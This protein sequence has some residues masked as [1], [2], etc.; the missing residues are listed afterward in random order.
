MSNFSS[1]I[2]ATESA[3][4]SLGSAEEENAKRMDSAQGK[5]TQLQSAWEELA[6]KTLSSDTVK[7]FLS[8]ATSLVKIADA[9]GGL[10]PILT[11]LMGVF[12]MMNATKIASFIPTMI[13]GFQ[14]MMTGVKAFNIAL[15]QGRLGLATYASTM[16]ATGQATSTTAALTAA[17]V[18][19]IGAITIAVS[20]L[21]MAYNSYQASV[22]AGIDL[23]KE[24]TKTHDENITAL[25]EAK[26]KYDEIA[27]STKSDADKKK[28]LIT[29]QK[30]L[31]SALKG[32]QVELSNE[33]GEINKNIEAIKKKIKEEANAKA[34]AALS[35]IDTSKTEKKKGRVVGYVEETNE[36]TGKK[37]E[38]SVSDAERINLWK[39]EVELIGA[40][41]NATKED[42]ATANKF[43][44]AVAANIGWYNEQK[45]AW[46]SYVDARRE[47]GIPLTAEEIEQA[48]QYRV[49]VA[50]TTAATQ[51]N[52][53]ATNQKSQAELE[54]NAILT[55]TAQHLADVSLGEDNL[56]NT[57]TEYA[58]VIN[59]IKNEID[60]LN[61]AYTEQAA[62]GQISLDT[63]LNL[64]SANSD[65]INYLSIENGQII[66]NANAQD[67]LNQTKIQT[68]QQNIILAN[69]DLVSKYATE[70]SATADLAGAYLA[71]ASAKNAAANAGEGAAEDAAKLGNLQKQVDMIKSLQTTAVFKGSSQVGV[72]T[73]YT[74]KAYT[75]STSASKSSAAAAK[76]IYKPQ[77]DWLQKY[78]NAVDNA[79]D[80]VDALKSEMSK[81][82]NF[83]K[84]EEITHALI[85]ATND[86][87]Y[88]T[89]QLKN[90]QVG[91]TQEAINQL[92]N[93][94]FAID[95]NSEKSELYI[96]NIG[97]LGA[98]T[99]DTAKAIEK[100]IDQTQSL[101]KDNMGLDSSIRDLT[102]DIS[103][104][105]KQLA[106]FPEKKLEKFNELMSE[107][108]E[109]QLNAIENKIA[110][111]ENAMKKDSRLI[112]LNKEIEALKAQT[113]EVDKQAELNEKLL[114]IEKAKIA[115][116][117]LKKQK[118]VQIYRSG[119]GWVK[120]YMPSNIVIYYVISNY[121]CQ[122]IG[123]SE[124]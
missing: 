61:S 41:T 34:G 77:I 1:A 54:A 13:T 65:Y 42:I 105:Y 95:Y 3:Y 27:N 67:L 52:T 14:G 64:I 75:P 40:K 85:R 71:L 101:N 6:T 124:T 121:I 18:P 25:E 59:A 108:Q 120:V 24:E 32:T 8:I 115:L 9:A 39:K 62:N 106:E 10:T 5:I 76:E 84:Q 103:D 110:D 82:E 118:T 31:N 21:V 2:G 47:Q 72:A 73:K 104:Y 113:E 109:S 96:N 46:Q 74:P 94:G 4:N 22:Q 88:Q 60:L 7:G 93:Y 26:T 15:T 38:V 28:E 99:G 112:A 70:G 58:N 89:Q 33:T 83:Q 44:E 102:G 80:E 16:V 111:L 86:Q 79:K 48:S 107:F 51:E 56:I 11:S 87:I 17:A 12:L 43:N 35:A 66:L 63:A 29:A 123:V 20:A 57:G 50:E 45:E 98:F 90:A 19:I 49:A 78:E 119:K 69:Q 55:E 68:A 36:A 92:R 122:R 23:A 37:K 97:R 30:E 114:N 53:E 100:L 81:T 91:Q 117:N 116:E